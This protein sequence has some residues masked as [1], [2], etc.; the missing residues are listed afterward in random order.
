MLGDRLSDA[1]LALK[2]V[3]VELV[4]DQLCDQHGPLAPVRQGPKR[5]DQRLGFA[6]AREIEPDRGVDE[7]ALDLGV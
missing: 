6:A 1:R 4:D 7:Q 5:D 2:S 3:A